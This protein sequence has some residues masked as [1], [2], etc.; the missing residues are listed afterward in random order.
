[1]IIETTSNQ[2]YRVEA[3]AGI[4]HAWLGVEVKRAKGGW[5]EK[6]K[7]RPILVRK[8]STRIVQLEDRAE[9]NRH[10]ARA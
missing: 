3:A 6:A 7:A 10:F 8:L 4:D 5:V 9:V 1:M 2:F